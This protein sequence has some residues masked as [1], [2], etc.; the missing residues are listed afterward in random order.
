MP[1]PDTDVKF[2]ILRFTTI[3]HA[4]S[5]RQ[6]LGLRLNTALRNTLLK[7]LLAN[8]PK[9]TNQHKRRE[10]TQNNSQGNKSTDDTTNRRR[11]IA[12]TISTLLSSS[13]AIVLDK[14]SAG[15]SS[16]TTLSA[17]LLGSSNSKLIQLILESSP[18]DSVLASAEE[19]EDSGFT[20]VARRAVVEK[21]ADLQVISV[22]ETRI[23]ICV[24]EELEDHGA[25][26][27]DY[28]G[29]VVA[30][31]LQVGEAEEG[32]E[33]CVGAELDAELLGAGGA[34][35][36]VHVFENFSGE[37]HA[38]NCAHVVADVVGETP[39]VGVGESAKFGEGGVGQGVGV[40]DAGVVDLGYVD[41]VVDYGHALVVNMKA[42]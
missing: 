38:S 30:D 2:S 37:L 5:P 39:L 27:V 22:G 35:D 19:R 11:D 14:R 6:T 17:P 7:R 1:R 36:V 26:V 40:G 4:V 42:V 25:G 21:E 8:K 34:D 28:A 18:R 23:D 9:P 31:L 15:T 10:R 13:S 12:A 16:V 20:G 29:E 24:S 32:H 41:G 3:Q 33:G